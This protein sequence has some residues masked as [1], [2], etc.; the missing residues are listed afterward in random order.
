MTTKATNDPEKLEAAVKFLQYLA[1][2]EGYT[3]YL[4]V[5]GGLPALNSQL[6]DPKYAE[7][8]LLKPFIATMDK[9]Q[10]IPWVDELGERDI[11]MQMLERVVLN[12]ENPREVL[13]SGTEAT[14]KLRDEFFAKEE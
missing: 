13:D 8:P 12:G 5:H 6:A 11:S 3:A 9:A 14:N 1:S 4:D 10:A 2:P 7:D